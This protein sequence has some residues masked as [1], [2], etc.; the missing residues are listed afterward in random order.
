MYLYWKIINFH[1]DEKKPAKAGYLIGA[2]GGLALSAVNTM[3]NHDAEDSQRLVITVNHRIVVVKRNQLKVLTPAGVCVSWP[4]LFECRL[5]ATV[6]G[7]NKLTGH[8][9]NF[10]VDNNHI[11]GFEIWLH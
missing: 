1:R 3:F 11:P 2:G 10:R 5:V 4:V 7:H 8:W 9:F 6:L